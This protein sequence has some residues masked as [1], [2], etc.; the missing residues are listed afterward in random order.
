MYVFF[1]PLNRVVGR[2]DSCQIYIFTLRYVK[3]SKMFATAY[4]YAPLTIM[5]IYDI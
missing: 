5:V 4:I 2:V 3:Q 1:P